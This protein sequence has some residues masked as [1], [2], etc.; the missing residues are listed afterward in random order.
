MMGAKLPTQSSLQ[1]IDTKLRYVDITTE[2]K[3]RHRLF[4][5]GKLRGAE[6]WFLK[7]P[8]NG[9]ASDTLRG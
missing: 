8:E 6:M 2:S 5:V 9:V 4:A 3:S 1:T 7:H